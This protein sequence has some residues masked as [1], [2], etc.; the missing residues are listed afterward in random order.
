MTEAELK[1]MLAQHKEWLDSLGRA[2]KQADFSGADL[3]WT[4]LGNA[5]LRRAD[6]SGA[7]L[8][9]A[10][11]KNADLTWASLR[12]ADL[13]GANLKNADLTWAYL[14]GA[15]LSGAHL[16]GTALRGA[17]LTGAD[18]SGTD[19]HSADLSGANFTETKLDYQIEPGLLQQVAKAA[20]KHPKSLKMSDWHTCATTHCIAGWACHLAENGKEL[21]KSHGPEIAG[22][23]LLGAEA[24]SHFFDSNGDA[25]KYLQSVL[26][27]EDL[28]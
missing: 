15:D 17:D 13:R 19:L 14:K 4:H 23:L 24:H 1:K 20:L 3:T 26:E 5:D 6:L 27:R 25:R 22:L 2:G 7:D 21:E 12:G 28:K 18:L 9:G 8:S 10:N 11:L 16:S